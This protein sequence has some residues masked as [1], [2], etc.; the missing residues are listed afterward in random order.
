MTFSGDASRHLAAMVAGLN[1]VVWER[2]PRTWQI[3]YVN[4][5]IEELLGHSRE[6]WLADPDLWRRSLHPDDHDRVLRAVTDAVEARA[7]FALTYRIRSAAGRLLWVHHLGHVAGDGTDEPLALHAVLIDVTAQRRREE[8]AELLA[9]ASSALAGPGT[10]EERLTA[11]A[12]LTVGRLCD[13][14]SIWLRRD[15]GRYEAVAAAPAELAELVLGLAPVT[16]PPDVEAAHRAGRPFVVR[17]VTEE[18][19]RAA[20]TDEEHFEALSRVPTSSVLHVPLMA[21]QELTG[22]LSLAS[23]RRRPGPRRRARWSWPPSWARGSPRWSPPRRSRCASTAC[24][25]SP[26]PSPPRGRSPRRRPSSPTASTGC[27][28]R[29]W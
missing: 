9:A 15:D 4:E 12:A 1:A 3:H 16:A 18:M 7:D 25:R 19:R 29:P 28:G 21:G 11:V 8:A 10:V 14:S 24:T 27:S 2:D 20:A 26:S 17:E 6:D 13:R 5:R 23:A 22:L